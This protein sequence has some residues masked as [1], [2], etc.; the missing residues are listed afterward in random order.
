VVW[1][2]SPRDY[3]GSPMPMVLLSRQRRWGLVGSNFDMGGL[4]RQARFPELK[5][6]RKLIGKAILVEVVEHNQVGAAALQ[7]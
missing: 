2:G 7:L 5:V 6:L 3:L 1:Q 4:S